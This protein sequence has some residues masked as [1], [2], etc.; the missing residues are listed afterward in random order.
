MSPILLSSRALCPVRSFWSPR[1]SG[2]RAIWPS[3][4]LSESRSCRR[5]YHPA[6]R[7]HHRQ[8]RQQLATRW[9][10]CRR[11]D[12]PGGRPCPIGRMPHA[13][14]LPHWRSTAHSRPPPSGQIRDPCGR[15]KLPVGPARRGRP[16]ALLL[17]RIATTGRPQTSGCNR[18]PVYFDGRLWISQNRSLSDRNRYRPGLARIE[19]APTA[20]HL[21]LL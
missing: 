9:R 6:R 11:G 19:R 5:R 12:S 1:R 16:L 14:R 3:S 7:R 2:G 13:R 20:G 8:R 18:F 4:V 15:A 17:P 10:W 21:L